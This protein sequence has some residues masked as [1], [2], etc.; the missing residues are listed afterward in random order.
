MKKSGKPVF[1]IVAVLIFALAYT[2][3]FDPVHQFPHIEAEAYHQ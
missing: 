3:F 2:A 1:F